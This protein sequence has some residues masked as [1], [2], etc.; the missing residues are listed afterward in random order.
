[1]RYDEAGTKIEALS[2]DL[3]VELDGDF[4][5]VFKGRYKVAYVKGTS[6]YGVHADY[7]GFLGVPEH[8]E[9][10]KILVELA[11]TPLDEREHKKHYIK[12]FDGPLG[13]L[14]LNVKTDQ[15]SVYGSDETKNT[16]TKFTERD[17][18]KLQNRKSVAI[19]WDEVRYWDVEG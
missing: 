1:M 11:A 17:I 13:F 15:L 8:E 7:T 6:Q 4:Y 5:V 3:G 18:R 14:N 12:V 10:F 2:G 16:K 9:V 19:D